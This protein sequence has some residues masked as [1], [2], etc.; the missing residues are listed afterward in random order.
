MMDKDWILVDL[1]YSIEISPLSF[2]ENLTLSAVANHDQISPADDIFIEFYIVSEGSNPI[3]TLVSDDFLW[4][5]ES[6]FSLRYG[7]S[8]HKVYVDPE[9][10]LE[11]ILR[12][13]LISLGISSLIFFVYVRRFRRG[14]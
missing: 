4:E 1:N 6:S 13:A 12:I 5:G 11:Y 10:F 7:V 3:M 8:F 14:G 9:L 2:V